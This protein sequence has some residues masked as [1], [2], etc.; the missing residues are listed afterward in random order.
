MKWMFAHH[1]N[2]AQKWAKNT[3]NIPS[4]PKSVSEDA[5]LP[6]PLVE[7]KLP[8]SKDEIRNI[9]KEVIGELITEKLSDR[10]QDVNGLNHT[11]QNQIIL[12]PAI[13]IRSVEF[14]TKPDLKN[15]KPER[16][17]VVKFIGLTRSVD[18]KSIASVEAPSGITYYVDLV[19]LKPEVEGP[20]KYP[21]KTVQIPQAPP[22]K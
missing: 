11:Y 15:F 9:I 2:V 10:V 16:I 12:A 19:N 18:G 6:S 3:P 13:P 20:S 1:P 22:K 8:S 7:N 4:L 5:S 17:R 21:G 14:D